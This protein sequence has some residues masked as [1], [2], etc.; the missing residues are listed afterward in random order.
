MRRGEVDTLTNGELLRGGE[1]QSASRTRVFAHLY[2][3]V[4]LGRGPQEYQA[5]ISV[6][7]HF[8]THF[9]GHTP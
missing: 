1:A 4:H 7:W 8:D 3:A 9:A 5:K 6:E 2:Q